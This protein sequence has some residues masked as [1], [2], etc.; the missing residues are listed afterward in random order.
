MI[1]ELFSI[2]PISI[3]PFG[4]LLVLALFSA[5]AQLR[6]GMRRLKVGD[7]DV[8]TSVLLA[9]AV[10]GIVGGKLY[11]ALLYG[12]I[13]LIFQR[14]GIVFY[15]SLIGGTIAVSALI[16]R[17]GLPFARMADATAPALALGYAVGRIGCLLVGDDF[18]RP[19]EL[20]WGMTFPEGPIPTTASALQSHFGVTVPDGYGPFDQVPV[21]PTQIYETL[22]IGLLWLLARLWTNPNRRSGELA[23]IVFA[24][25]AVER[26]LVE[27]LRAKDDRFL[28]GLTVAQAISLAILVLVL[29][30]WFRLRVSGGGGDV[31]GVEKGARGS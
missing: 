6:W 27:F 18:G 10:G 31:G 15:G 1:S 19:T 22:S 7:E 8:A 16:W 17:R 20:P 23:L 4:V 3:S 25:M 2:G 24:G 28:A 11:Y 29:G 26:F 14:A 21:H 30:L 12:D 9:A 5:F 13:S